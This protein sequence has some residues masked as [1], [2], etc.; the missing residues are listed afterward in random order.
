MGWIRFFRRRRW[1]E[2]RRRE[3]ATYLEIETADNITRGMNPQEA[4]SAAYRKLGNTTLIHE[5]IYRMNSLGWLETLTQ[6]I[7]YGARVLR[8]SPG[9]TAA[10]IAILA[11]G[12][13]INAVI[14]SIVNSVLLRP[15]PFEGSNR[16]IRIFHV[17]PQKQFPGVTK[18]SVSPANYLDWKAQNRSFEVM[19]AYSVRTHTLTGGDRPQPVTVGHV[20]PEFFSI[21]REHT[22]MGRV[23]ELD[24][25]APGH[26]GV[27]VITDKFWKTHL[28]GNPNVL[29][30]TLTLDHQLYRIVGVMT[31]HI[32]LP[33]WGATSADL[34][35]P[36]A[37]DNAEQA[38]RG[39]HNYNVIARLKP[40]VDIKRAGAEMDAISLR[41]AREYPADDAGWGATLIPLHELIVGGVR[42]SLWVLSGAVGFV[43]LI[44]CANVANL[45]LARSLGRQKEI[46]LR[47]ALGA[48]RSR[49]LRQI[50]TETILLSGV[51][52]VFGLVVAR[53]VVRLVVTAV[54]HQL[55]RA[56]EIVLD[57]RVLAFTLAVSVLTGI[58]A[59]LFPALRAGKTDL[60]STLK[61]G[62]GRTES[63]AGGSRT[64]NL[65]VVS[66]VALSLMLLIGAGLMIRT[67]WSL[68]RVNPG[69]DP[70][71]VLTMTLTIPRAKYDTPLKQTAFYDEVLRRVRALPSVEAAGA[72]DTLPVSGGGSMQPITIDARAAGTM[73]EQPEVA[74]REATPGYMRAMHI[75]LL[76]GR[77]FNEGDDHKLLISDSMAKR[78][79]PGQNPIGSQLRFT[80]AEAKTPW[81]V[82]GVVGDVKYLGLSTDDPGTMVY[83]WTKE[84]PWFY[85]SLVTRS[86]G[87]PSS[88]SEPITG[89]VRQIDPELPVR[90]VQTMQT[91][92]ADSLA[93]ERFNMQL[94]AAFAAIA[95]LLAAIGIYSLLSYAV[96]RRTREIGIRTALGAGL[97]DVIR[98]VVLEGLKPAAA[99]I[100]LGIAGALAITRL[101][102][103]LV[104]GV[105][106]SDP[107]TFVSVAALLIVISVL[108]SLIPAY[109]A[110]RV[111]PTRALR[112]E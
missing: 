41:L 97:A 36:L 102:A 22:A 110:A 14:F 101:L 62:L 92:V 5:E 9:Y 55:P 82:I 39:N 68:R 100:I 15:L 89:I 63:Q 76:H 8:R 34:W 24:E 40:G 3:M 87:D 4:R 73:A 44:A 69:F 65:L 7:R 67:L 77:D 107:A 6:D 18:F 106:P 86:T 91:I 29:G 61:Q 80:L 43:L 72:T 98:M 78:F 112:E 30:Q 60:N 10:V 11:L 85:L 59:G 53:I 90:D 94:L 96:R 27:A 50:L 31:P 13:G 2:A 109:R 21:V 45:V 38:I 51:G 33:S 70:Q 49:I 99:G 52:G 75:P 81:E 84:R 1:D 103:G 42:T 111:D 37:W 79:W 47:R 95:L 88:L 108:A 58:A 32:E 66:E 48:A 93:N 35:V 104:H 83:Q 46:A 12:I 23:F 20:H 25:G 105:S 54:A 56:D 28:G 74:V 57:N 17:P 26:G 64:R 16:L 19:S 71:H